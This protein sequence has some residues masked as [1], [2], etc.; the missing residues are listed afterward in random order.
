MNR[1]RWG[2]VGAGRIANTFASDI[3]HTGNAELQAVAA[4]ELSS[5][6]AFAAR[7]GIPQAHGGYRALFDNDEVDAVYVATP[8]TAHLANAS[9]ALESG[10][11]VLCEKPI[12]VS[13]EECQQLINVAEAQGGYLMEAMWTW[14]LPALRKARE[15]LD[16][17]RIGTLRHVKADFGYP[18]EYQ[19]ERREYDADLGGGCLLEMGVYPVALAYYFTGLDPLDM[20]VVARHAPNGVEDDVVMVFDYDGCVASLATSFRC[21]LQN[22]A[23]VIGT[24][25]YIAIPDFWRADR[26]ELH[27][28]DERV[29]S[30]RDGR[31]GSGFEF[32]ID[33]VGEDL[34]NGCKQSDTV[35]WSASLAFQHHMDR[36]RS[37][38]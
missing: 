37:R 24:D 10:K 8:H 15:W 20:Q 1:I 21:K 23:Y 7:Y 6:K 2:I 28:L 33:S 3:E 25:G 11:A 12:T 17:G 30:F 13:A 19:P 16:A 4:R 26:C 22:W 34:L 29:D 38:F 9:E 27:V 35:P 5:A 31:Q 36:V 18:L 32:Q 14:F